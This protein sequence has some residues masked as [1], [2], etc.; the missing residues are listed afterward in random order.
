MRTGFRIL[1]LDKNNKKI[2]HANIDK[3]LLKAI[4]Y[5]HKFQ[6]I[7]ASKWLFLSEDSKEKYMLLSLINKALKQEDQAKIFLETSKEYPNVYKNIF[8]IYVQKPNEDIMIVN[9]NLVLTL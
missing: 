4:K 9:Y 6:Y 3:N 7:E 8:D 2:E 1:V 5:I